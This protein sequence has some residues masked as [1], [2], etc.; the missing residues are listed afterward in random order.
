MQDE[1]EALEAQL[2]KIPIESLM[3]ALQQEVGQQ[4]EAL[5][6][7]IVRYHQ[8]SYERG[9][10]PVPCIWS[11]GSTRLLDY[12]T[13]Q[14]TGKHA[15]LLVPS[16]INRAYVLDMDKDRSFARYLAAKGI[17]VYMID[18]GDPG[19][20]EKDFSCEQY[21]TQRIEKAVSYLNEKTGQPVILT[22]YC[23]GGM[24]ALA[25]ALRNKG[26]IHA[27]AMLATPWDFHAKGTISVAMSPH[28]VHVFENYLGTQSHLPRDAI[29]QWF[30]TLQVQ[31]VHRKFQAFSKVD[32]TSEEALD[33]VAIQRWIDD[34][35]AIN[36]AVIE[37]CFIRWAYDN[38]AMKGEWYVNGQ[39][40]KPENIHLPCFM[41]IPQYDRIVPPASS[42]PLAEKIPDV[43]VIYPDTGHIG[44][45]AGRYAKK[46]LWVP[47][48]RWLKKL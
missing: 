24:L 20:E 37:E 32:E 21:I 48:I 30:Y 27:L 39:A 29:R 3:D 2:K 9:L 6:H 23:M 26:T 44:M 45:V 12:T 13:N 25:T 17:A 15:V 33:F 47:F 10:T 46:E 34:G 11:Q 38:A 16:L 8:F 18:W 41:A 7:G 40:M 28:H 42:M 5:Q 31:M 1:A 36:A 4:F 14:T 35:V 22:G 43:Q 19:E